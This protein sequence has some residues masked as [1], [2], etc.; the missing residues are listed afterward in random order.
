MSNEQQSAPSEKT[1]TAFI[2]WRDGKSDNDFKQLVFRGNL[3][4]EE[5]AKECCFAKS[6]LRQN[7][8]VAE[9]LKNLETDLRERNILPPL[10]CDE[11]GDDAP[12]MRP[13]GLMKAAVDK[14]RIKR[15]EQDN[16]MLRAENANLK[17]QLERYTTLQRALSLTG[18]VPR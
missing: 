4:R 8:R 9:A 17:D 15:L 18:R 14:E 7:P 16:A 3:N 11:T 5:I 13:S 12:P 10:A 1:Y 2:T 6:V